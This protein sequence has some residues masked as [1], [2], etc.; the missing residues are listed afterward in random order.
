MNNFDFSIYDIEDETPPSK[1]KKV[2]DFDFG[3]KDSFDL[4]A[5][6][7]E[8]T[9]P[10]DQMDILKSAQQ[11]KIYQQYA[12]APRTPEQIKGMSSSER[13]QYAQDLVTEREYLQSAGVSKGFLSGATLGATEHIEA[14]KPQPHEAGTGIGEFVGAA[15][16]ITGIAK[17]VAI[18]IKYALS[19]ITNAP[20]TLNAV[21]K[22][23][24]AFGTGSGYSTGKQLVKGEG[25][26]PEEVFKTGAEFATI[27]AVFR[28]GS[29]GLKWI[30]GLTPKQ[31]ASILEKGVIPDDLPKS[32]YETAE[33]ALGLLRQNSGPPPPPL[34]GGPPP[35]PGGT[36]PPIRPERITPPQDIGL[37]PPTTPPPGV[38]PEGH[39]ADRVGDIFS[40]NRFYNTTQGGQA[41]KNEVMNLDEDVYRGVNEL[42]RISR[43]ANQ[44]V[45]EI[46][47]QLV[48]RLANR[49]SE[50]EA[51]PEPSDVQ[52]RVIR[53]SN[54]VIDALAQRGDE[55]VITGYTPV[56]NQILIDQIQALRQIIDYDF[57][58]GNTKNIFRPII[59]DIQDS[60]VRAAENSAT[61]EAAEY[62]NDARAAYRAWVEAFDNPYIRPFR[63]GSNQDFS[64]LFK[65]ALDMDESNMLRQVLNLSERGQQ[66]GNASTREIVEKHLSRYFE[67]PQSY[68]DREF[69]KALR[70]LE[71]V[72]TPQQS[73]QIRAEFARSIPPPP[74]PQPRTDFRAKVQPR[75]LTADEKIAAKHLGKEPE[76]IQAMMNRRTGIK[77]LREDLSGT[78]IKREVFDRL[79]K[80]KMRSIL[81]E[82]NIEKE[83]TGDDLYKFL[84][85]EKNFE[86]FSEFLGEQEA[87]AMRQTAKE[88]G[89]AQVKSEMRRKTLGKAASHAGAMKALSIIMGIL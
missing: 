46:H 49:V 73:Q 15:L 55:G 22:L 21:S 58:H 19:G 52:R 24:T 31:Q 62:F 69:A 38:P 59:N 42:Y 45:V 29:K 82:G 33:E 70:E 3:G 16:P 14:L 12:T 26:S 87:E 48:Q 17:A 9:T 7:T 78:Q 74:P 30:S 57:A 39:L 76:D 32:Q 72:I 84:N 6:E 44:G 79:S 89:K 10:T 28:L 8:E 86:L 80:Q 23:M 56:N 81:R 64:K 36:S 43:E 65:S 27:D 1:G 63:D 54:N 66:L 13:R 51:I 35:P 68:T 34:G 4:D 53:A 50:L 25:V 85:K 88:I 75:A 77:N 83:F 61:P 71:A 60:V 5:Y 47:P 18:P 37:R 11:D 20:K 2:N 41:I 67:N 40:P